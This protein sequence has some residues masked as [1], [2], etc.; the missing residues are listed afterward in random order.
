LRNIEEKIN[1]VWKKMATYVN[2]KAKEFI[3]ETKSRT[4]ENKE[5]WL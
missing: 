3:G 1:D 4:V 5:M 2:I